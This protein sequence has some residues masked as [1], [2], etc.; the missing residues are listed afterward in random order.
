MNHATHEVDR[1]HA[2]LVA[3]LR[4]LQ[5]RIDDCHLGPVN[6]GRDVADAI[7]AEVETSRALL[8]RIEGDV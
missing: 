3:A 8:R 4:T 6:N 2:E 5:Q 1:E 7:G